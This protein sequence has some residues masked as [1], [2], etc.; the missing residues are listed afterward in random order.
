[1]QNRWH[2][3][4]YFRPRSCKP[5]LYAA[6]VGIQHPIF[7]MHTTPLIQVM[8]ESRVVPQARIA[9]A[10]TKGDAVSRQKQ[11]VSLTRGVWTLAKSLRCIESIDQRFTTEWVYQTFEIFA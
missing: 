3:V 4:V 6:S 1:M 11:Q 2:N 7:V 9:Q 10:H 8:P 5:F